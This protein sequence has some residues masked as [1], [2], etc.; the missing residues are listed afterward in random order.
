[1]ADKTKMENPE[2]LLLKAELQQKLK[3]SKSQLNAFLE[4]GMPHYLFGN[5]YRFLESEAVDWLKVYKPSQERLE[6]QFRDEK[7]RTLK[8]YV[9][10][11]IAIATLRLR[12]AYLINLCN[13]GMP[14]ADVGE[15]RF[16]HIGDILGFYKKG[17]EIGAETPV[18]KCLKPFCVENPKDVPVFIVD[19]SY[20]FEKGKAGAGIVMVDNWET[21]TGWSKVKNVKTDKAVVCEFLAV[22]EALTLIKSKRMNKALIV[23]DQENLVKRM[24]VDE[25]KY[26]ESIRPQLQEFNRLWNELKGKVEIR[27]SGDLNGGRKNALYK[28]AHKLSQEYK[29][30][31]MD[32]L[33]L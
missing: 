5:Q 2:V 29:V 14:Y 22:L 11:D 24:E 33:P 26:K 6:S 17:V 9:T 4:D 10:E 21:A 30:A 19:G 15:K 13:K 31:K 8:E 25:R 20:N 27:F 7:G 1:M 12:K 28:T 18:E 16:Y 23:T 3:V 32:P